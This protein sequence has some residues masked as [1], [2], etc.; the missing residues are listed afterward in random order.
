MINYSQNKIHSLLSPKH[1]NSVNLT[2]ALDKR[3][4]WSIV[5]AV[6]KSVTG[7]MMSSEN[8]FAGEIIN[9]FSIYQ[10]SETLQ[11]SYFPARLRET[12]QRKLQWP[13]I[14]LDSFQR[15]WDTSF[16]KDK[17]LFTWKAFFSSFAFLTFAAAWSR[18]VTLLWCQ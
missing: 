10:F 3:Q 9:I 6:I 16:R 4:C 12:Q 1:T 8:S 13:S 15:S 14:D 2:K 18:K 7:L 5:G 17:V 11:D